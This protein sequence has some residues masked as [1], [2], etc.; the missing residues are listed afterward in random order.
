MKIAFSS[1]FH[2]D[3]NKE[4][5][6]N[7]IKK[8][9][10]QENVDIFCFA[11]DM[12]TDINLTI[13]TLKE[14]E[15]E[16]KIKVLSV[17]GN[18]EMWDDS[19]KSSFDIINYFNTK[20]SNI[21]VMNKPFEF[22]DWVILGNMG[23]YDFTTAKPYFYEKQLNKMNYKGNHWEDKKYCNWNH[24]N[25][26]EVAKHFENELEK[27]LQYYKNK[28][29]ILITHIVPFIECIKTHATKEMNYFNAFIGNIHIGELAQ[30]YNVKISHFGH[31]HYHFDQNINNIQIICSPLGYKEEWLYNDVEKSIKNSVK[32]LKI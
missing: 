17:T 30:K 12:S 14:I 32:F 19:F 26:K 9:L 11:G 24:L 27:Q 25:V 6:I 18:H 31:T 15:N 28:N 5:I 23:W 2:I 3:I 16:L 22:K 21:S 10:K 4:N 20:A 13:H 7:E 1:D 8:H 29:I